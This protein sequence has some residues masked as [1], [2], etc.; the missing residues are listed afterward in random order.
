VCQRYLGGHLRVIVSDVSRRVHS[1]VLEL[2]VDAYIEFV[3][4]VLVGQAQARED[5]RRLFLA[6]LL[7]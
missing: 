6:E 1:T 3:G 7:F 4:I 2:D 5:L